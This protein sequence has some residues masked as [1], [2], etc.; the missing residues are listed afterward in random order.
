M[1]DKETE[2]AALTTTAQPFMNDNRVDGKRKI[3]AKNKAK[4]LPPPKINEQ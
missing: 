2:G 1:G 4:P 3:E